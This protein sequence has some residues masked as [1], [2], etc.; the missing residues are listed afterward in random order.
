MSEKKHK[1]STSAGQLSVLI[2]DDEQVLARTIAHFLTL[3]GCQTQTCHSARDAMRL[4]EQEAFDVVLADWELP[5]SHGVDLIR[6]IRKTRRDSRI[7]VLS[8]HPSAGELETAARQLR[9]GYLQK[10]FSLDELSAVIFTA[11]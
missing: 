6:H 1:G 7:V 5:D 3:Q 11:P 10:P 9:T 8:A 2:I 4:V